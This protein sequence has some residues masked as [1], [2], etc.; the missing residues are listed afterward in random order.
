MKN[1]FGFYCAINVLFS[2]CFLFSDAYA[3]PYDNGGEARQNSEQ[4]PQYMAKDLPAEAT[5]LP[6]IDLQ[7]TAPVSFDELRLFARDWRK[8]SRWLKTEGNE[9]KAVAYLGVSRSVDY[10]VEVMKWMDEHGWA[11]DRFFLLERKFRETLSIQER[12]R[13]NSILISHL[14]QQI[15]QVKKNKSLTEEQIKSMSSQYAGKIRELE[16]QR[17]IKAPVTPEEYEL[18]KLN[19]EALV[20]ILAD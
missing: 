9:Y 6:E 13:K 17:S 4:L 5:P 18:I 15:E 10:P 12:E 20:K 14:Q 19:H 16:D 1:K 2:S 3:A 8:Y 11:A 7:A